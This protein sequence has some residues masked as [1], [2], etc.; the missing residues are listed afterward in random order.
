MECPLSMRV[1]L[2]PAIGGEPNESGRF[3]GE[4]S[5][6]GGRGLRSPAAAKPSDVSPCVQAGA[7]PSRQ[8]APM[9]CFGGI[10]MEYAIGVGLAL[11]A[12]L[13][14]HAMGLDRG[15]AFYATVAMVVAT[16]Y[17]LFAVM[18]G[19]TQ[20]LVIESVVMLG[21]VAAAVFMLRLSPARADEPTPAVAAGDVR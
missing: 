13:F 20:A 16:Y 2:L 10:A 9:Q 18:G 15:R 6:R 11:G 21:F 4:P 12:A 17:V 8:T 14:A 7:R 19:S 5:N 3:G 1:Y